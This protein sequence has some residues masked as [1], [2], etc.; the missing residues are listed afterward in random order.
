MKLEQALRLFLSEHRRES[1]KRQYEQILSSLIHG[2]GASRS[3]ESITSVD[4][5]EYMADVRERR[6]HRGELVTPVTVNNHIRVTRAFFNWMVR[7]R[8][9]EFSP[10]SGLKMEKVRIPIDQDSAMEDWE[11]ERVLAY[12][13]FQQPQLAVVLFIADTGCRRDGAATLTLDNLKMSERTAVVIEKGDEPRPVWFGD[14]TAIALNQWLLMRGQRPHNFVFCHKNGAYGEASIS[15]M[16]R[17]ACLK[18]G[19]RSLGS[20]SLRHRKGF[21]LADGKYPATTSQLILGHKDVKTT[22]DYYY[23]RD[24]ERARKA[25]EELSEPLPDHDKIDKIKRLS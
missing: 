23:P 12:Y 25:I 6:G 16:I 10:A 5:R 3:V 17:R 9:I 7:N 13:R 21:Q 18:T 22:L 2:I 4:L 1:T 19:V 20:H 14:R 24:T 15:R 11:L 8:D